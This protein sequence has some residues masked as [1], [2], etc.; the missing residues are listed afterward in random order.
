MMSFGAVVLAV[1]MVV[2]SGILSV[3]KAV[4][5]SSGVRTGV[6]VALLCLSG[7]TLFPTLLIGLVW[8]LLSVLHAR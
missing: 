8:L 3:V 4:G 5:K 6:T 7:I 1:L 2:L